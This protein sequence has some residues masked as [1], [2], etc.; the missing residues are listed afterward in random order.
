MNESIRYPPQPYHFTSQPTQTTTHPMTPEETEQVASH[1]PA[2]HFAK[3]VQCINIGIL[4]CHFKQG[5]SVFTNLLIPVDRDN[6]TE[7]L[8]AI[9]PYIPQLTQ[10][11]SS[12]LTQQLSSQPQAA[13]LP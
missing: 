5:I 13:S 1:Q 9:I 4:G 11:L 10:Q 3:G 7:R 2:Y 8:Q 6:I 12:Q